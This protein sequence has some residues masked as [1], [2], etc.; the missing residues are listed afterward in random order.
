MLKRTP[1]RLRDFSAYRLAA[2]ALA[3]AFSGCSE[4]DP[5][6]LETD[7][8]AYQRGQ[9]LLTEGRPQEA[10]PAFLAVVRERPA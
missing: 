2:L 5:G 7:L 10:L 1:F 6:M 9:R 4:R 3:L 8:K